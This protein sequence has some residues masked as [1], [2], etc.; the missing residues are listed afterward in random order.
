MTDTPPKLYT[1]YDIPRPSDMN[2]YLNRVRAVRDRL[3][4]LPGTPIPP[5]DMNHLTYD[6]ANN[7]ELSLLGAERAVN[8]MKNSWFMSGEIQSGGY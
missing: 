7:I 6:G 8:A 5:V 3:A 2:D 4:V 1:I